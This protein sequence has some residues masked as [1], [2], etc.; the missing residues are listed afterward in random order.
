M[1]D[2]NFAPGA[3]Y[4]RFKHCPKIRYYTCWLLRLASVATLRVSILSAHSAH[5]HSE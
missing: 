4:R 2:P 1:F 3:D 5:M